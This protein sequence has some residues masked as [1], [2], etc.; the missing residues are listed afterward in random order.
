MLPASAPLPNPLPKGERGRR[1]QRGQAIVLIAVMLAVL[2][3]MTALA[4]DGSR[5]YS[6]RGDL[7]DAVDAAALAAGDNFQ[8]T[9]SYT[10]AEQAATTNFG[11]NLFLYAAP[12]CAPA[13]G[14]PGAGGLT[15]TCTFADGTAL[16]QLVTTLGPA[17]S[18]FALTATRK[19]QLQFARILTNGAT[20]SLKATATGSVN[21]LRYTPALAALNQ[22]GCGGVPGSAISI[23]GSG[24]ADVQGD[25]VS[26]GAITLS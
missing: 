2:V 18:R 16:T 24:T 9:G 5:A 26:N 15:V 13:Y 3:G 10:L 7:Q 22:A 20:P 12:A 6:L 25:V 14:T 4:V 8:Q 1:P 21:N 11:I 17:G 23:S 19:L